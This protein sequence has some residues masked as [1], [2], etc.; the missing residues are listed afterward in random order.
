MKNSARAARVSVS[1]DGQR[2]VSQACAVLLWETLRVTGLG[3]GLSENLA[4]WRAPRGL[5]IHLIDQLLQEER[6]RGYA[7]T[8]HALRGPASRSKRQQ[9][10]ARK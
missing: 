3:R 1:A 5:A 7:E 10:P 8:L 6:R 9:F 2:L 4:R